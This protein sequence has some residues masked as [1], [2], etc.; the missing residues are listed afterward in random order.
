MYPTSLARDLLEGWDIWQKE[1]LYKN[2]WECLFRHDCLN[3]KLQYSLVFYS[4]STLLVHA[5]DNKKIFSKNVYQK[6]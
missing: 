2:S 5:F 4:T 6:L 1:L 3:D